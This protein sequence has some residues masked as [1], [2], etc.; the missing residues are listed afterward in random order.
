MRLLIAYVDNGL[1]NASIC[2]EWSTVLDQ[3]K[4]GTLEYYDMM[5][6]INMDR[7][8]AYM[9]DSTKPNFVNW[10]FDY[11][12]YK[13]FHRPVTEDEN[14]T[15]IENLKN[16]PKPD[17]LIGE[18]DLKLLN[19]E[20]YYFMNDYELAFKQTIVKPWKSYNSNGES[21]V[22]VRKDLR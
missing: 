7:I 6:S 21:R 20:N 4:E 14:S 12:L 10:P 2:F 15:I 3:S 5:H 8:Y 16:N 13:Y 18:P 9:D 22:Y 11:S 19:G 1:D 17:V